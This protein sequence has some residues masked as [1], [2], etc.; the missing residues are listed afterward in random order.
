[1]A[2]HGLQTHRLFAEPYAICGDL[3]RQIRIFGGIHHIDPASLYRDG[4]G[5]ECSEMRGGVYTAGKTRNNDKPG[6]AKLPRERLCHPGA[7]R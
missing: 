7:E 1:M 5:G 2:R 4:P 6:F 3:L